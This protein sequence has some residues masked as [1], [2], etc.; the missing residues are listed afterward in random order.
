MNKAITDGINFMP[1]AFQL[2][3][4]VWSSGDGTPGS[5]TYDGAPNAAFVPADADF[6]GCLE[7]QKTAS[8]QKLRY[9]GQT[10]LQ[11]GC[12]LQIRVRIKAISGNLPSVRVAG[13][14]GAAGG[15]HVS[16]VTE[17][18]PSITLTSYGD[19]VEVT[20]I[21]G[22]GN[23]GGVDMV[24]GRS[25]LFGHFGIDL[26]GAN[27]GVVRIDD[28]EITDI[29]SAFLRDMLSQVDVRDYGA[30][31]DGITDDTAAFEA[32]DAAAGG[33]RLFVPEGSYF[34]AETVSLAAEVEF[35]GTLTMPTDKMLLLTKSF[36]LPTYISAFGDEELAFRKAFQALLNGSDHESLDMG[37]RNVSVTA[38]IDM[39]AAV[40][41]RTSYST[42]RVIRNGQLVAVA[43]PAWETETFTSQATYDPSDQRKLSN[44][45][46]IANIPVGSLVTGAGVGRE[47]YVRSKN[48]GAG[49][50]TLNA[51]LY[52]AAGTQ[53]FTFRSFKYMLDFSGFSSL[54]KFNMQN[55]EFQCNTHCSAI[56]LAPFGST[57]ALYDCFVSRPKDRGIT[58][59]GGGCQGMLIDGCQ[60]LS[61]EE[62]LNVPDRTSI[63]FNANANDVKLRHCRATRFRHFAVMAGQNHMILGNHFFQGDAVANGPRTAGIVLVGTYSSTTVAENYV[64]N[65]YLEWTNEQDP[66]PDF[67]GGFSFSAMSITDNIFLSGEV[68]PWFSYIVIKPH[69]VG[70]FINGMTVTGNKFRS[71]NGY[72]DRA[73]RIDTSFAGL[74]FD[75]TKDLIYQG[76]TYHGVTTRSANP[77][78]LEFEQ[79]SASENWLIETN[80]T[81]PFGAETRG[82]DGVTP[83]GP[84]AASDG[85][86]R[87]LAPYAQ[88]QQGTSQDQL[89]LR[90]SEPVSGTVLV[91]VR[92]DK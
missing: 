88:V 83:Q 69:G 30:V 27:G 80:A 47:I 42:R 31:G 36:D 60:F 81:L 90:W 15:A 26:V 53:V 16:G 64:D 4:N 21:V 12:Y 65:C 46:N 13:W 75:R 38:P 85:G 67:D 19:V 73:E 56:R 2:G 63:G 32:A 29:T 50:I 91:T 25:A 8:V 18:G 78:R 28:I 82:V 5:D 44:V 39:Q 89:R 34:L 61:A 33:R 45:I 70:H 9:M 84:L 7:L 86:I 43:G 51:P 10:P 24:W 22:S 40:P 37:G 48:V 54:S 79:T 11:P 72:I 58:S 57:F 6:G 77:L 20:G 23:R 17:Q 74:N 52:D 76:N 68:A 35:E 1:P 62:P 14:A 55:I 66:I 71:I 41:N 92:A 59:I 49:E 3:L 87:Y